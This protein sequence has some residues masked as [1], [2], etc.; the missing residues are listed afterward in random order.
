LSFLPRAG[1]Y[2]TSAF[3]GMNKRSLAS[4]QDALSFSDGS[5]DF[6]FA[7]IP[8]YLLKSLRDNG[9]GFN[10]IAMKE[11]NKDRIFPTV[12]GI[13]ASPQSLATFSNPFGIQV[14]NSTLSVAACHCARKKK[15]SI[16]SPLPPV[17]WPKRI[18]TYSP[19]AS[20]LA[21][22]VTSAR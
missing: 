13:S 6:R 9:P 1:L 22:I 15:R 10:P 19:L 4:L 20:F 11:R 14:L 18:M 17:V 21:G 12:P 8:G 16:S 3:Y 7:P 2:L 5:R